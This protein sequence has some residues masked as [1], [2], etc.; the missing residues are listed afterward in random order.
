MAKAKLEDYKIC[1][2]TE[3]NL[4]GMPK[5]QISIR[6]VTKK[7]SSTKEIIT[8]LSVLHHFLRFF[9]FSDCF[10]ELIIFKELG[11]DYFLFFEPEQ[12][13]DMIATFSKLT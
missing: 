1:H 6:Q 10:F 2:T 11:Q 8:D 7:S 13:I 3:L 5:M 12:V 9:D 4:K